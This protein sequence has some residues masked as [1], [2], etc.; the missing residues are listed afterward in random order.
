MKLKLILASVAAALFCFTVGGQVRNDLDNVSNVIHTTYST[1]TMA[2][3]TNAAAAVQP[4]LDQAQGTTPIQVLLWGVIGLVLFFA[5]L[6]LAFQGR[7]HRQCGCHDGRPTD[8]AGIAAQQARNDATELRWLRKMRD[9]Q[10][11][12]YSVNMEKRLKELESKESKK[13]T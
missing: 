2:H 6:W 11:Q 8:P 3:P 10:P 12:H 5:W 1:V 7:R 13:E 9:E 4:V